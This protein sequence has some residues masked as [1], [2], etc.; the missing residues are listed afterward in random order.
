MVS[1]A[2]ASGLAIAKLFPFL[3]KIPPFSQTLIDELSDEL[4]EVDPSAEAEGVM[5]PE[6]MGEL[7]VTASG[8]RSEAVGRML[9]VILLCSTQLSLRS[10][11]PSLLAPPHLG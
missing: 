1:G 2:A 6:D 5:I 3:S 7:G 8:A 11:H 4:S 10:S 9:L